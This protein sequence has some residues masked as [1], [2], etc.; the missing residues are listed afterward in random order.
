MVD[1][2]IDKRGG[3]HHFKVDILLS[4]LVV[5]QQLYFLFEIYD[6]DELMQ[7]HTS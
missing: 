1:S 4:L 2:G 5:Y 3:G 7:S 6:D